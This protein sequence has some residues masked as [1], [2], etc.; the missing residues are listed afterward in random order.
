VAV[1]TWPVTY[2]YS[3]SGLLIPYFVALFCALCT[4]VVGLR[5]FVKNGGSYQN[6]FSTYLRAADGSFDLSLVETDDVGL[7][8]LPKTLA[9]QKLTLSG[10]E[11]IETVGHGTGGHMEGERL[12]EEDPLAGRSHVHASGCVVGSS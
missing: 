2:I 6:L 9:R 12:S 5:A 1:T 7:D 11:C 10:H 8:P 3:A 4:S